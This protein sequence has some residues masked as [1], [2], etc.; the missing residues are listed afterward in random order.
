MLSAVLHGALRMKTPTRGVARVAIVEN[1]AMM[2]MGLAAF[3][4]VIAG[5]E[6]IIEAES[7]KSALAA[8]PHANI[9]VMIIDLQLPDASG[10]DLVNQVRRL[11]P[12]I[13]IL[14]IRDR[15]SVV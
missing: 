11:Y 13:R 3:L 14:M 10:V 7:A 2:R 1:H 15:K 6:I 12:T 9:D 4:K 5:V 8:L